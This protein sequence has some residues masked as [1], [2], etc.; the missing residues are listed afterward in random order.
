MAVS[1]TEIQTLPIEAQRNRARLT[2]HHAVNML[3]GQRLTNDKPS[4]QSNITTRILQQ[5]VSL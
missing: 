1:T 3:E 5:C 4:S 2:E